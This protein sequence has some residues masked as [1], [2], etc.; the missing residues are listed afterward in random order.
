LSSTTYNMGVE[1][2]T[3]NGNAARKGNL[4]TVEGV[5]VRVTKREKW[6]KT[7]VKIHFEDCGN[8]LPSNRFDYGNTV[9]L[10]AY[11]SAFFDLP[12]A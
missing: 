5:T 1:T 2:K 4:I 6:S 12:V 10:V 9:K 8:G 11:T 7:A 3:V